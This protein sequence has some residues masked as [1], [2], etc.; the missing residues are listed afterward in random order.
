[1]RVMRSRRASFCP[2]MAKQPCCR[3]P[4][5]SAAPPTLAEMAQYFLIWA[6]RGEENLVISNP[7]MPKEVWD[8]GCKQSG[9][10]PG[11][12]IG[13]LQT[14]AH[15]AAKGMP[16]HASILISHTFLQHRLE[17]Q[18]KPVQ[19]GTCEQALAAVQQH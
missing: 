7:Q 1:M 9:H 17:R 15:Q 5:T 14:L 18:P 3:A 10:R 12:F 8:R 19:E 11:Y 13:Q 2:M 16:P 6:C 4:Q